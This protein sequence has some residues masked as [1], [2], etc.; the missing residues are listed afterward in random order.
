MAHTTGRPSKEP[1]ISAAVRPTYAV[2]VALT[3]SFCQEHL[4]DEHL[5]L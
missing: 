5:A 3:D 1:S 4:N 2:I